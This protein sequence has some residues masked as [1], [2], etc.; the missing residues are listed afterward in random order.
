MEPVVVS[1]SIEFEGRVVVGKFDV[2]QD[3]DLAQFYRINTIPALL[4]FKDG[5]FI[6]RVHGKDRESLAAQ[7]NLA[8]TDSR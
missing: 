8:I 4:L 1:I 3:R 7:L 6:G 2:D 5:Q